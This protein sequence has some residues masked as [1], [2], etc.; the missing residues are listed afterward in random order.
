MMTGEAHVD[1]VLASLRRVTEQ[2]HQLGEIADGN[3]VG[4]GE[5]LSAA[6]QLQLDLQN[7]ALSAE[8]VD[9]RRL[10]RELCSALSHVAPGR[11][12]EVHVVHTILRRLEALLGS[13]APAA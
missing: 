2:E 7:A 12:S 11:R 6:C 5:M 9:S 3:A 1:L 4:L 8:S 13:D 10:S